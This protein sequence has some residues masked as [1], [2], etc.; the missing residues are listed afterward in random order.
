MQRKVK[1]TIE[2]QEDIEKVK[3]YKIAKEYNEEEKYDRT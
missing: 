3:D 1:F 2:T